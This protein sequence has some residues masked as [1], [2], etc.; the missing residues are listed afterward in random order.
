[1]TTYYILADNNYNVLLKDGTFQPWPGQALPD[2]VRRFANPQ[3]PGEVADR[4]LPGGSRILRIQEGE[5]GQ[6][7]F[8]YL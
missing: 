6:T 7:S 8:D 1:M 4:L 5:T 3:S 2:N